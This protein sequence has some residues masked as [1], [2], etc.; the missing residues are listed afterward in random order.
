MQQL[1]EALLALASF[2]QFILW[3]TMF[4]DGKLQ[5]L[6]VDPRT[7]AT[8]EKGIDWQ[9]DPEATTDVESALKLIELSG[10]Q[11]GLGFLFTEQDPFFFL[12]IDKC[13][14]ESREWSPLAVELMGAFPGAA[15]EVSQSGTGLHIFGRGTPI[16][17]AKK[18]E[19]LGIELYTEK[20]FVA[21]TGTN[22]IGDANTEHTN[23]LHNL[24]AQ[25]FAPKVAKKGQTWTAEPV[26]EWTGPED[27]DELI[28]KALASKSATAAFGGG[29]TFQQLWE[30]DEEALSQAFPPNDTDVYNRSRA[31][32][33]IA[34]HLAFW[35]GNNCERIALLM[36][37]SGLTR[38]K[39]QRED[40]IIVT[41]TNAVAMQ[42]TVYT[43]TDSDDPVDDPIARQFNAPRFKGSAK[44]TSWASQVR[45]TKLA[46]CLG[47]EVL[48]QQLCAPH[49]PT[50]QP[51]FWIDNQHAT[52]EDIAQRAT[53]VSSAGQVMS[54]NA[55][56]V[57]TEGYQYLGITQQLEHFAGCAYIQD[58]HRILT[59]TGALLKSEQFNAT[60]G[61]YS[62][63]MESEG[64]SKTTKKA[65][66]AFTE[67]QCI[68]FPKA[69][70]MA[71]DPLRAPGEISVRDGQSFVNIYQP[72]ETPS[73]PGDVTLF[74]EH[75]AKVLPNTNDQAILLAYMAACIQHKGHKF[76]WCPVLQGV[77]GNG[78]TLFTRVV[79]EAIGKRYTHLPK[80][81][82]ID[83][84][85][86]GWILKKLF[87][88]VEDIFIP[89][90]NRDII[91]NLKP[92]IT[93]EDLEIQFKGVDQITSDICANFMLNC[94]RQTG[95]RKT[96]NDRRF[97][98][99][100]TAQQNLE[101]L[102]RDGMDGDYF[103]KLYS[104]LKQGDGYAHVTHFLET[105]PIPVELNPALECG[106]KAKRAPLTSSTDAAIAASLGGVEQEVLEAVAQNKPGFAGGWI[107]S[108]AFERLLQSLHKA[109]SIPPNR[110]REI[111]Q[112]LGYD[113]HPNLTRGQ[114]NNYVE[115]DGGR[116]RLFIKQRHINCNIEGAAKIVARY[117]QDQK[118]SV[119][120][121]TAA[122]VFG[123]ANQN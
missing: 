115:T 44:Q 90:G 117:E 83:S 96:R 58:M 53:P 95:V 84:D 54:G 79:K 10:N 62:F 48:I 46:E 39:W 119:S 12:D 108:M 121:S 37:Q 13:L 21:L 57:T 89:D 45:A 25:Y 32:A 30:G 104:W 94:N 110:R 67:S 81:S 92:M 55:Q 34:Q 20:R 59:P 15:I 23:A 80:A 1:P 35:T 14:S 22:A 52:P 97:C 103:P 51:S 100:Y 50:A 56:A 38:D 47:D 31:D 116:P 87:I 33:A 63:Q 114:T 99:F 61:G 4:R 40:Y 18:N 28:K 41:V 88:G 105:Y 107:S 93:G 82:K 74:L 6:P 65:W 78:K 85:F 49:G 123:E 68:R 75:L 98:V 60:Y 70:K 120:G 71:F 111:L 91:E 11:F 26:P 106:G 16:E 36:W 42:E 24:I 118:V 109:N 27:D 19:S 66:E 77:E 86:N 2:K 29:A 73:A 17:H 101:D 72:I 8:F 122:D 5:K 43:K 69:E 113:W 64:S 9:N 3:T 102:T 7:L 76:Q 112:A